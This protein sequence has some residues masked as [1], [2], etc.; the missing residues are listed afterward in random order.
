MV[1]PLWFNKIFI[2]AA[3]LLSFFYAIWS[4]VIF[5]VKTNE[6]KISWIIHQI[7]FNFFGSFV[8][9]VALWLLI[10]NVWFCIERTYTIEVTFGDAFLFLIA[11]IGVTGHLPYN[12]GFY[13]RH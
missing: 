1:I 12:N 5:K 4:F 9:W 11:F 6:R 8:G 13:T 2:I 3:L 7:W 10:R